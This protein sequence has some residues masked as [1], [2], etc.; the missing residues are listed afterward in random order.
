M[1]TEQDV[2]HTD[3][4]TAIPSLPEDNPP[5]EDRSSAF[6]LALILSPVLIGAAACAA[7]LGTPLVMAH[8]AKPLAPVVAAVPVTPAPPPVI[9]RIAPVE[10]PV[11]HQKPA[12][13]VRR[14]LPRLRHYAYRDGSQAFANGLVG[15]AAAE[16]MRF[17]LS[18]IGRR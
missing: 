10:P 17:G 14:R 7:Y 3:L 15:I 18:R 12:P 5:A 11:V 16:L 9:E 13:Q 1:N 6:S 2:F 8:F 4:P